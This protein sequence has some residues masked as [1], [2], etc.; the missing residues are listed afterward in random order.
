M[1]KI[2][3]STSVVITLNKKLS[4]L[5]IRLCV[6]E[7]IMSGCASVIISQCGRFNFQV[8]SSH[9]DTHAHVLWVSE[10]DSTINYFLPKEGRTLKE[11]VR[12]VFAVFTVTVF[13]TFESFEFELN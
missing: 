5:H 10:I 1:N 4:T 2:R 3:K 8:L 11:G 9:C 7:S 6:A 12:E 13:T